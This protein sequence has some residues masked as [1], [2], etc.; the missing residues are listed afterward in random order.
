MNYCS[1]EGS[2]VFGITLLNKRESNLSVKDLDRSAFTYFFC[3]IDYR[4]YFSLNPINRMMI[5]ESISSGNFVGH[6]HTSNSNKLN[7]QY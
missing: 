3:S 4:D 7:R 2:I 5:E 6:T 1:V